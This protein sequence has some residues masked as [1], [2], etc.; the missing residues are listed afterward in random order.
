MK[1]KLKDFVLL[2]LLAALMCA[3]DF[4]FEFLPNIHLVGVLI[5][6]TTVVYRRY[7]LISVYIYVLIQGI[8]GGF[9]PWWIP[10]MYI[11][12][13]LWMFVML[14]PQKLPEKVKNILYVAVCAAHGYLFGTLYAPSQVFLFFGGD[15]S[16][17]IPWIIAGI[18]ADLIHGTSNLIL[19]A[20]AI[21]PLVLILRRTDR[22]F[23][24]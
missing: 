24:G 16:K 5:V 8:V 18:P 15:F 6:V 14:I 13:F 2:A 10:Y 3:G 22:Y 4:L 17:M 20:L 1:L 11:W 7:A 9:Q 19:G 23:K 12:D 21:Y